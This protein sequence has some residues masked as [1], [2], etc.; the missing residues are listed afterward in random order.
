MINKYLEISKKIRLVLPPKLIKQFYLIYFCLL[1][2]TLLEMVG[3]GSIPFFISILLEPNNSFEIFGINIVES[4]KNIFG[5]QNFLIYFPIL[6]I[7]TFLI[8]NL[9]MILIIFLETSIIRNIKI[10]FIQ[11]LFKIYL[12]KPYDF[13][14]NKNSSEILKNIFNESQTTTSMIS[15]L[16]RFIRELTIFFVIGILILLYEPKISFI[17]ISIL[18]IFFLIFYKALNNYILKL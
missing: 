5:T 7:S 2:A 4:I 11:S 18:I 16:L 12:F 9:V 13:Y 10:Y 17:A 1:L 14:L 8:K 3:L 6:I 15:N